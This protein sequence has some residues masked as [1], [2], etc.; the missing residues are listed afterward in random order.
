M[1]GNKV[2]INYNV[3]AKAIVADT[4]ANMDS[5]YVDQLTAI[6]TESY[7]RERANFRG[8]LNVPFVERVGI[9]LGWETDCWT[10]LRS[11]RGQSNYNAKSEAVEK[12]LE[13]VEETI[14]SINGRM[15]VEGVS[16]TPTRAF[17]FIRLAT[18]TLKDGSIKRVVTTDAK[19]EAASSD[20]TVV[21]DTEDKVLK[22]VSL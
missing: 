17:P 19:T 14:V 8:A 3:T 2:I 1:K 10:Q 13:T 22:V 11:V 7:F 9:H 21:L 18:I 6:E 5:T 20:R 12:I 16:S 4:L 15:E